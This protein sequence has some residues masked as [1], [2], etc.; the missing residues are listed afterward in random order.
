MCW[1][2]AFDTPKL[3]QK[4]AHEATGVGIKPTIP[5]RRTLPG[6][7]EGRDEVLEAGLGWIA[8]HW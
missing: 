4:L 5:A 1:K 2:S 3:T 8:G 6:V 7:S